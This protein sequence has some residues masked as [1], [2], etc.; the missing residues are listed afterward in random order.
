MKLEDDPTVKTL[1]S[2]RLRKNLSVLI[3]KENLKRAS[4]EQ[5]G[6]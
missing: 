4:R 3:V 6:A 2:D 5:Q 1:P